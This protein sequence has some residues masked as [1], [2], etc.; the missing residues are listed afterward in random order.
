MA[1]KVETDFLS[2]VKA[3]SKGAL[4]WFKDL[5]KKTQRAAF[6]AA[7]GRGDLRDQSIDVSTS[8]GRGSIGSMYFFRYLAKWD[9]ILPYWDRFPLIFPF[10]PAKGGF[11]GINLHYLNPT[12]RTRLMQALIKAQ[13][14]SGNMDENFKLKLNYNII[15]KFPPAK[16]CIKRYLNS[17]NQGGFFKIGGEDWAYAVGLPIQKWKVNNEEVFQKF[18]NNWKGL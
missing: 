7:T 9:D 18:M 17:Y 12:A 3:K 1:D 11:Y 14:I 15:T 2:Q 8:L 5:V 6:P 16:P 10:A 4:K 13:G